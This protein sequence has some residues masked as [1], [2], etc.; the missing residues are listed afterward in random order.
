MDV[1]TVVV[2]H[3]NRGNDDIDDDA[4]HAS[5]LLSWSCQ[6]DLYYTDTAPIPF[7]ANADSQSLIDQAD[8]IESH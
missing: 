7:L 8:V 3:G 4:A 1:F 5:K 6:D 2:H